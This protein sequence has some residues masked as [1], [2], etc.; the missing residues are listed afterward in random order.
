MHQLLFS[1]PAPN[2][3]APFISHSF[4]PLRIFFLMNIFSDDQA[5]DPGLASCPEYPDFD[6]A[7]ALANHLPAFTATQTAEEQRDLALAV[8]HDR[9]VAAEVLGSRR[10]GHLTA[11]AKMTKQR[12]YYRQQ[13]SELS[14][15]IAVL[16]KEHEQL[17][18]E[19]SLAH[20]AESP[21]HAPSAP[22][23]R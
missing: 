23:K 3:A 6:L 14:K 2:N 1:L 18:K 5:P 4:P 11:L 17:T 7:R 13:T 9:I 16:T 19:L 21:Y 8:A 15:Q 12:D 20:L 22:T 10:K